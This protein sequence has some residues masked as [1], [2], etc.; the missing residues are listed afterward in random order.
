MKRL[1]LFERRLNLQFA[2]LI[3][4]TVGGSV[5]SGRVGSFLSFLL[6]SLKLRL[7]FAAFSIDLRSVANHFFATTLT[8]FS[9]NT[10]LDKRNRFQFVEVA[11]N[12]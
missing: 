1:R 7:N 2:D 10:K 6:L 9:A 3:T 12:L 11:K 4:L 8:S 5:G